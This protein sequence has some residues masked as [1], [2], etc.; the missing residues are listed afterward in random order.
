MSNGKRKIA[1][2]KDLQFVVGEDEDEQDIAAKIKKREMEQKEK[3]QKMEA[4]LNNNKKTSG[5]KWD[6]QYVS[7]EKIEKN[8]SLDENLR[9]ERFRESKTKAENEKRENE[10]IESEVLERL[11]VIDIERKRKFEELMR[12]T[13]YEKDLVEKESKKIEREKMQIERDRF[14]LEKDKLVVEKTKLDLQQKYI[15][16]QKMEMS[17]EKKRPHD[18]VEPLNSEQAKNANPPS[19]G[20][21]KNNH[22]NEP[23]KRPRFT[24]RI[25]GPDDEDGDAR[26]QKEKN[27]EKVPEK[28]N[29]D[30][31]VFDFENL[32][33]PNISTKFGKYTI[34]YPNENEDLTKRVNDLIKT[35]K[36]S[37]PELKVR[38]DSILSETAREVQ[39]KLDKLINTDNFSIIQRF[40]VY[41]SMAELQKRDFLKNFTYL[42]KRYDDFLSD[43]KVFFYD[44]SINYKTDIAT[45]T[46][47]EEIN[48][49]L[50]RCIENKNGT[51][52]NKIFDFN[53]TSVKFNTI[54]RN[55]QLK[56]I[57][58]SGIAN[59]AIGILIKYQANNNIF[60]SFADVVVGF[61]DPDAFSYFGMQ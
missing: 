3:E 15:D 9:R 24:P 6:L 57:K 26:P 38:F 5:L 58:Y 35:K 22:K 20:E 60:Y 50:M 59:V 28:E 47:L 37:D 33:Q 36:K 13:Q 25:M 51:Y 1:E 8:D 61:V 39:S 17:L 10:R 52:A 7:E 11:K 12:N 53:F 46:F 23:N 31:F 41:F 2:V 49:K 21:I 43:L 48:T 4:K 32:D 27:K 55:Y 44:L 42:T 29:D 30:E 54:I 18:L 14:Q 40:I 56:N 34:L 45:I 16:L 19:L